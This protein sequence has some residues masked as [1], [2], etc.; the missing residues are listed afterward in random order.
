MNGKTVRCE[1][2]SLVSM[3]WAG[4]GKHVNATWWDRFLSTE[5]NRR[6]KKL[7]QE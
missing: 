1:Q 3:A 6:R 5:F 7:R 2:F 4:G